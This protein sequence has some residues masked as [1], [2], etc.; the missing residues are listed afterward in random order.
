MWEQVMFHR[1]RCAG[2]GCH[3]VSDPCQTRAGALAFALA[4]MMWVQ[5]PDGNYV[6]PDCAG[7]R[8]TDSVSSPVDSGGNP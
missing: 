8:E 6:C 2:D 5:M 1:L 4:G 3:R 7:K